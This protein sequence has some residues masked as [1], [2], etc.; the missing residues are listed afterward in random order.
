[1]E[2]PDTNGLELVAT[3]FEAHAHQNGVCYWLDTDVMRL[4]GY[5]DFAAFRS[6]VN[7][8][9]HSCTGLD[10]DPLDDFIRHEHEDEF[11]NR[12][13]YKFTRL[14]CFLI[15]QHADQSKQEVRALQYCLARMADT[16]MEQSDFER[17]DTR[18]RLATEEKQMSS[19]AKQHGVQDYAIFK[20]CGYR[21]MYNMSLSQLK[22]R[23]GFTSRSGTL[24]DRMN[25]TELAANLFRI[26]QTTERIK[27]KGLRG[28][29]N[30][31]QAA[32][33]VGR[34]VRRVMI[35]N[36]GRKPEALPLAD[37]EI[38]D[39]KKEGKKAARNIRKLDAPKKTRKSKGQAEE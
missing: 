23:K 32:H 7:K 4:L 1:M 13:M 38:K 31:E 24:Y 11:G 39:L 36:T 35:E 5:S 2:T 29:G 34:S 27:A 15:A 9:M 28:Q 14:A 19:V 3:Q 30:L 16:V 33:D 26:T 18:S 22:K 20:D 25:N 10:I 6:I 12:G 17:L 8:A 21:G 37:S